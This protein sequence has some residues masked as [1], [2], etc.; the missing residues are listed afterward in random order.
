MVQGEIPSLEQIGNLSYFNNVFFFPF[1]HLCHCM[2]LMRIVR[3]LILFE[4]L[5]FSQGVSLGFVASYVH[6]AESSFLSFDF[7]D[8]YGWMA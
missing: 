6:V 5:V 8:K 1:A 3:I 7:L 4:F 2:L